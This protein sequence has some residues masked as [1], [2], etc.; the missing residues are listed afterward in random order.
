MVKSIIQIFRSFSGNSLK[1]FSFSF[2]NNIW[3]FYLG[4]NTNH[5]NLAGAF[6]VIISTLIIFR[7]EIY[8]KKLLPQ[9]Q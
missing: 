1:I 8:K 2:C 3:V 9:K 7:R 4:R 5:Q 6:L